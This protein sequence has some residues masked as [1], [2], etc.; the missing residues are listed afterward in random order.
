MFVSDQSNA[1]EISWMKP[2]KGRNRCTRNREISFE[3]FGHN[4][5]N[6]SKYCIF[7]LFYYLKCF[8]LFQVVCPDKRHISHMVPHEFVPSSMI[9]SLE[10]FKSWLGQK[11]I[12]KNPS[13]D[14]PISDEDEEYYEEKAENLRQVSN[15]WLKL[16]LWLAEMGINL[17]TNH[18]QSIGGG[19]WNE[20]IFPQMKT[21]LAETTKGFGLNTG[22]YPRI[23]RMILIRILKLF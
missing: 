11:E 1:D 4:W 21:I 22:D 2:I 5:H 20:T 3:R 15:W 8:F 6:D 10:V 17:E 14:S 16:G 9:W 18:R 19:I 12:L 7:R 13:A 23:I